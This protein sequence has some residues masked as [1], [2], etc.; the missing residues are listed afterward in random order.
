MTGVG[1]AITAGRLSPVTSARHW[2]GP[3]GTITTLL[4]RLRPL[5][6]TKTPVHTEGRL[7]VL[8]HLSTPLTSEACESDGHVTPCCSVACATTGAV[9]PDIDMAAR[10]TPLVIRRV[11]RV[12]TLFLRNM[13]G[14]GDVPGRSVRLRHAPTFETRTGTDHA[15]STFQARA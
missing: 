10:N 2:S 12:F 14:W 11:L 9:R 7:L 3:S 15:L 4:V 8:L 6:L 13:S 1:G 5:L